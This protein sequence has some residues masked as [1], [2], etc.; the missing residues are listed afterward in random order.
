MAVKRKQLVKVAI[1]FI[2]ALITSLGIGWVIQNILLSVSGVALLLVATIL[3]WWFMLLVIVIF[4]RRDGETLKDIGF[5]KEKLGLQILWG[6]LVAT[7]TLLIFVILPELI[8]DIQV[9]SLLEINILEVTMVL[10]YMLLAVA[11]VEEVI[12]RGYLFK[13]LKD[14]KDNKWFAILVSS[15]LFGLFHIFSFPANF[16]VFWLFYLYNWSRLRVIVT[17]AVMGVVWCLLRVKIKHCT[18]LS[19]I[20]AN[21]L[22]SAMVPVVLRLFHPVLHITLGDGMML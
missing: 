5:E 8:F 6:F 17:V 2:W 21:A 22:H 4:M 12:F 13:K 7:I 10:I 18:L 15:T 11:L 3:L 9:E 16:S 14:I 19:L 1:T 20:I